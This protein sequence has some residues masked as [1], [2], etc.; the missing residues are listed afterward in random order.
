MNA[1]S[2]LQCSPVFCAIKLTVTLA[3][4]ILSPFKINKGPFLINVD[5][6]WNEWKEINM[7]CTVMI[8]SLNTVF[9]NCEVF[10]IVNTQ[11]S[12][13]VSNKLARWYCLNT[14]YMPAILEAFELCQLSQNREKFP[15]SKSL[16]GDGGWE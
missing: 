6:L 15:P 1:G 4:S 2:W 7:G 16:H 14:S 8:K 11:I 9:L 10:N 13:H 5:P 3:H 12:V